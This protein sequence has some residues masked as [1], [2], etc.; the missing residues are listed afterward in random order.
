MLKADPQGLARALAL[1]VPVS[2]AIWAIAVATI[3]ILMF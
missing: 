2:A 3:F 1:A